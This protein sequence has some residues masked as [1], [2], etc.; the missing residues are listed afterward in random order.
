VGLPVNV[1]GLS[2]DSNSSD[3]QC[4][5]ERTLHGVLPALAGADEMSGIG[6][7]ANGTLCS[8]A[9]MVCD[10]ELALAAKKLR[11]G[12]WVDEDALALD[13]VQQVTGEGGAGNYLAEMHTVRHLRNSERGVEVFFPRLPVRRGWE[14]WENAGHETM[15]SK[16]Q[17]K[18]DRLLHDHHPEPLMAAQ[19]KELDLLMAAA[20]RELCP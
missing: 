6:N 19:E 14:D 5:S 16:A 17:L 11:G 18:A 10:N 12:I 15:L 13:V 4:G 3:F 7:L 20:E 8:Y 9:Q 1:Y 2:S